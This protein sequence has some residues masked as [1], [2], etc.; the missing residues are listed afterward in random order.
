MIDRRSAIV[1]PFFALLAIAGFLTFQPAAATVIDADASGNWYN[2]DQAGH[3]LQIETLDLSQGVVAWYTFDT[4]G[5]PLWLLGMGSIQG[6]TLRAQVSEFSGTRFPPEFD[7]DQI[8]GAVWGEVIFQRTGCNTAT[9][10]WIPAT[11]A[12]IPGQMALT[13]LTRIDGLTCGGDWSRSIRWRPG[14]EP[15]PGFETLFLDYPDGEEDFFELSSGLSSLPEPWPLRGMRI[16]GN[17][18]SDD[19]KMVLMRPLDGLEPETTYRVEL[20]M[21]F[22]TQEPNNCA[23]VGG[24]P[25]ESVWLRM[26]AASAKPDFVIEDGF[27][28]AT[29]DL[30][31][32][33]NPGA[34]AMAAG[35]MTN[36]A[37]ES[38]CG[39]P[40]RPWRL[41]RVS[42]SG[43]EFS[44]TS[45][46]T[47]RIWV[48]GLSDSGFEATTT[49]Y[50]T[51]F[52]VRLAEAGP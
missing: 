31:N 17:N 39:D 4:Q 42:T 2:P 18:H 7:A 15:E 3:G 41:K 45:D 51:E 22:A 11:D 26:G 21:Q 10:E 29:L 49:W 14:N 8:E 5:N 52:V 40:D 46:E 37:D 38:L 48:Y 27:R 34:D 36:G 20:E 19:L 1:R 13:R 50:L 25:G 30:G 6:D 28:R 12:F 43:Q 44:V 23:G 47:G 32:Q 9:V 33:S 24:S 16:S 35:D